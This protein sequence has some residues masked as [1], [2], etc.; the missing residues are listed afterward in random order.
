MLQTR[1]GEKS[2]DELAR[3]LRKMG[4]TPEAVLA[5]REFLAMIAPMLVADFSLNEGYAFY[6]EAPLDVP[7]MAFT[8]AGDPAGS[9][10]IMAGWRQ[11]TTAGFSTRQLDGGHFAIFDEAATVLGAIAEALAP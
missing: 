9:P 6:P 4:G 1:V 11:V 3:M 2:L 5:D 7:V 8:A 10:G